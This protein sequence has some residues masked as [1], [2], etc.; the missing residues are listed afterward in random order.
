MD[1]SYRAAH[2]ERDFEQ[3]LS[4]QR[5]NH[6]TTISRETQDKE[7]F[8]YAEHT[9]GLLKEMSA[10]APQI[11]A[12]VGDQLVGY[13][14]AM[15]PDMKEAVPSLTPMFGQFGQC[16]Y[17]GKP[18]DS[19]PFIVGGQVCVAEGFRGIGIFPGLYHA[20]AAHTGNRFRLC[21]TEIAQ[22]NQRSLRAHQKIGF[23]VIQTYSDSDE[24]WDIVAWEMTNN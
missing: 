6:Y 13:T 7:G 12:M 19:Y 9:I 18:L 5:K 16:F 20:L 17:K 2:T 10:H 1:I 8:V 22:R 4:L 15:T 14:L 3:L 24:T 11:I 21:V 23:E